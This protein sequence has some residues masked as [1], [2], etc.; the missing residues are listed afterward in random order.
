[1]VE[2]PLWPSVAEKVTEYV[3][4][5][6]RLEGGEVRETVGAVM[7]GRFEGP[8]EG[9]AEGDTLGSGDGLGDGDGDGEGLL[10]GDGDGLAEVWASPNI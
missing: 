2:T 3:E 9:T 1:M 4:P 10:L 6:W 5:P 8:V 7:S